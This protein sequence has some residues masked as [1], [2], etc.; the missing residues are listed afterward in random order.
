MIVWVWVV[1]QDIPIPNTS[2]YSYLHLLPNYINQK[3]IKHFIPQ[4][5][6]EIIFKLKQVL[7]T[8]IIDYKKNIK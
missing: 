6:L 7:E 8:H 4:D 1:I 5:V 2:T 3:I